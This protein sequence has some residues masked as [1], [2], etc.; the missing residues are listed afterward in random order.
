MHSADPSV[1]SPRR[2]R[3]V[4][5]WGMYLVDRGHCECPIPLAHV[6]MEVGYMN[7]Y[8][9]SQSVEEVLSFVICF[10]CDVV[11]RVVDLHNGNIVLQRMLETF[12]C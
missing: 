9:H 4:D 12:V 3:E 2:V 8:C 10:E 7:W 11:L 1:S 6:V 5:L